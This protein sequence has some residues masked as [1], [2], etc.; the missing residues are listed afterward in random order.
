VEL[1]AEMLVLGKLA[2]NIS[3][4]RA[5]IEGAIASGKAAEIF[6]RMVVALG[7][8]SDLLENHRKHLTAAPVVRPVHAERSGAV[9]RVS[10]R[11]VGIAVVALGGGRT[12][13]QDPVDH[14]VG[15][16]EL[17]GVGERVDGERPLGIVHARNEEAAEAAARAVRAAYTVGETSAPSGKLILERIGANA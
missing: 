1:S 17:A 13:P 3:E 7:G 5:K 8:P 9:Q 2:A 16:T 6:Q 12:R 10:T 11:E 14:A 15:L 4:A